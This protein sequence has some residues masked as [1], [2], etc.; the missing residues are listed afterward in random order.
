MVINPGRNYGL[1]LRSKTR[2]EAV[3]GFRFGVPWGLRL[4]VGIFGISEK[5]ILV[6][7]SP[8]RDSFETPT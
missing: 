5:T 8:A 2:V 1:R 7:G 4:V 3:I 6:P